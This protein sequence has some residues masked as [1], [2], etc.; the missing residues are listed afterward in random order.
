MNV[1]IY[2]VVSFALN[3]AVRALTQKDLPGVEGP[4]LG[5]L[6]IQTSTYG[7]MV[8]IVYGG[9]RISNNVIWAADIQEHATT[10]NQGGGKGGGG[11]SQS[12]TTYTYT[13]SFAISICEG[14]I[15]ALKKI[16]AN[17]KLIYDADVDSAITGNVAFKTYLG[18]ETQMPDPTQE[19]YEGVGNVP[20]YRGQAYIQFIDMPLGDYG[21]AIPQMAFEVLETGARE[22]AINTIRSISGS[23]QFGQNVYFSP[24]GSLWTIVNGSPIKSLVRWD[25]FNGNKLDQYFI[26]SSV[27]ASLLGFT[28]EG[29]AWI[30]HGYEADTVNLSSPGGS[31]VQ[32]KNNYV[33]NGKFI[34][35]VN[36]PLAVGNNLWY[37]SGDGFGTNW[38][39]MIAGDK[40]VPEVVVKMNSSLFSGNAA[41][42]TTDGTYLYAATQSFVYK[43]GLASPYPLVSATGTGTQISDV[44]YHNGYVYTF[45]SGGV[46]QKRSPTD[47]SVV[48]SLS[49]VGGSGS[50]N[51]MVIS[52]QGTGITGANGTGTNAKEIDLDAMAL[53]TTVSGTDSGTFRKDSRTVARDPVTGR[54]FTIAEFSGNTY[55]RRIVVGGYS[56]SGKLLSSIVTDL[57]ERAGLDSS[58]INVSALTDTVHGYV[59]SRQSTVRACLEQLQQAYYFDAVESDKK[60]KFVK[61]GGAPAITIP[62]ADLAAHMDGEETP[63]QYSIM[64]TQEVELPSAL[65]IVYLS[66]DDEYRQNTQ[67]AKRL[68]GSSGEA[69]TLEYSLAM[70][71]A[72]AKEIADVLLFNAWTERNGYEF[73]TTRKYAKYEPCDI[74]TINGVVLRIANKEEDGGLIKWQAKSEAGSVYTQTGIA[75]GSGSED[76]VVTVPSASQLILM[77]IPLLRDADDNT[78]FYA[79]VFGSSYWTGAVLFKS[80]DNGSSYT[81]IDAFTSETTYGFATN[82]LAN[83]TGPNIFDEHSRV[84]ISL[85]DGTLSGTTEDAVLNGANAALLGTEIIQFKNATLES[86]GTY[87]LTGLLRG[88]KGTEWSMNTHAIGDRFVLFNLLATHREVQNSSEINADRKYKAVTS[89]LSIANSSAQIFRNTG[90]SQKPYTVVNIGGGRN[91]SSDV[92]INW[93]RRTRLGGE[94]RDSVDVPLGETIE[95]YEVEIWD[96]SYTTLK[97]TITGLTSA[98]TTYTAAQQTTD[99]GGTQ[100]TVYVKIYQLSSVV[101]RGYESRGSI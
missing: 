99:F 22:S 42:M 14:P 46:I 6:K 93:I 74:V 56:S 8:P 95:S 83:W 67:I 65:N 31:N 13:C 35:Y 24:D 10:E 9:M 4:R 33:S 26:S 89:G 5:D 57:C 64:R 43:I 39:E 32:V 44:I 61:R 48:A 12:V 2:A 78:G 63:S 66:T 62:T 96:S 72:K 36:Y 90:V 86:D 52:E 17:G 55:L 101:G 51:V 53:I 91:S 79:G 97:R 7:S 81:Q 60:I 45:T 40:D 27:S 73:I 92:I 28:S 15:E 21:N 70:S 58:D 18:T 69:V 37:W 77:D 23:G 98:T 76:Q 84:N 94:L 59:I 49:G 47:L 20:A 88:R 11:P 68:V 87:T 54:I 100:T 71:D 25:T 38:I 29:K 19:A 30:H 1:L 80:I 3:Y 82:A 16:W 41:G 85:S 34:R 50:G 75:V